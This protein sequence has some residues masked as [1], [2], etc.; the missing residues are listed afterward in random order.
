VAAAVVT[1]VRERIVASKPDEPQL[2]AQ[3]DSDT[4]RDERA[5]GRIFG[6]GLPSGLIL[7]TP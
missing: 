1:A 7:E 6:E 2:A 5:L 4:A 3:L